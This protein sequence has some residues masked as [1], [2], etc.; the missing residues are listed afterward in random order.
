MVNP[1][2]R[3]PALHGARAHA[4]L[5][6]RRRHR[7]RAAR[8]AAEDERCRGPFQG[9]HHPLVDRQRLSARVGPAAHV[10]RLAVADRRG[11]ARAL[12]R[13]EVR[14][15][16][17][18]VHRHLADVADLLGGL[19]SGAQHVLLGGRAGV[20]PLALSSY[21]QSPHTKGWQSPQFCDYPQELGVALEGTCRLA[22]VQILS[23]QSKIATQIELFIGRGSD[24]EAAQWRRLGYLSLNSNERSKYM[25]RELK[26]VYIDATGDFL[27]LMVHRC[28]INELNLFNQ[29]G[30][31]ALNLLGDP[32]QARGAPLPLVCTSLSR[33]CHRRTLTPFP[34][35]TFGVNRRRRGSRR[36]DLSDLSFSMNL[37]TATAQRVRE[38]AAA[39]E[40][41][42]AAEDYDAAK[43]LKVMEGEL[44]DLGVQ[45]A[46][47]EVAK[48]QAVEEEDY[49][50][51]KQLKQEAEDLRSVVQAKLES[52]EFQRRPAQQQQRSAPTPRPP[53][54]EEEVFAGGEHPLRGVPNLGD[55]P[56]PEPLLLKVDSSEV[57]GLI[58]VL[59]EY[60][61]RCLY[62]RAWTLREA[63]AIKVL[64]VGCEDK[65]AQ[66]FLTT[67]ELLKAVVGMAARNKSVRLPQLF[68]L[69]EPVVYTLV[70]KLGDGQARV[71]D[72]AMDGLMA[73]ARCRAAGCGFI[74]SAAL[75]PLPKKLL[76][77]WRP[78]TARLQLL[79]S[80]LK[81]F[82]VDAGPSGNV[83]S[84]DAVM[85][86]IKACNGF[87]HPS[88]EVR[89][90]AKELTVAVAAASSS[91][92]VERHLGTLR[93]KQ[94]EEYRE[95]F[96]G[97]G[98]GGGGGSVG[99]GS[100][101]A[102]GGG[103]S[104]S[105]SRRG[106][107]TS[108]RLS[109]RQPRYQ[110]LTPHD[111]NAASH[112]AADAYGHNDDDVAAASDGGGGDGG[113]DDDVYQFTC[114]FCGKFDAEFTE[115]RLDLHYWQ[116]C[117][118]LMGCEECGQVIEISALPE[119]LLDECQEAG[120]YE[121]CEVSGMAVRRE[122]LTEWQ[123]SAHCRPPGRGGI[124][125]VCPLCFKD[126]G[127]ADDEEV[128][129]AHLI[130]ACPKNPR[131]A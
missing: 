10:L 27:R 57:Q 64:R 26:S 66:V 72:T 5:G 107:N 100:V 34:P 74:A 89:D 59:G 3:C 18:G 116:A 13:G 75:K 21:V 85:G 54:P 81:E 46:Q 63:A 126:L 35:S 47:L 23:H 17:L 24:Y 84:V 83:L 6:A 98:G 58:A 90:A 123:R 68:S 53:Q 129:R 111:L 78:I 69:L 128:W 52:A 45:L 91:A 70:Q 131:R 120:K 38:V 44:R 61:A 79:L 96:R 62:S 127:A 101:S 97:G 99:G 56:V 108:G 32:A 28:Y 14:G 60:V 130:E 87:A 105:S 20:E 80:L 114:Q 31:V 122:A 40:R 119:H 11:E 15:T 41:A 95:A 65:I 42:V 36:S 16:V 121:E 4:H 50:T 73:V 12:L 106:S 124:G 113:G 104:L 86:F 102:R 55:L 93:P 118:M 125:S 51:A 43:A 1:P 39:K 37:D 67:V 49:D 109:G 103:G 82:G 22:Q 77:A 30:I 92:A 7:V 48:L 2:P 115:E 94:L 88:G 33:A 9:V 19:A 29:V 110:P 25:A 112:A 76:T 8:A 117:P 71:R